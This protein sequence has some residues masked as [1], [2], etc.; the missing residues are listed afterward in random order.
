MTYRIPHKITHPITP[1]GQM[2]QPISSK[3][4]GTHNENGG[5][6]K[7]SRCTF[8]WAHRL[9]LAPSSIKSAS[10]VARGS[11]LICARYAVSGRP[12]VE[13]AR[14]GDVVSRDCGA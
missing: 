7:L 5:F 1:V 6:A 3:T 8:L 10:T 14:A 4:R 12:G 2:P 13:S 11:V 9:A